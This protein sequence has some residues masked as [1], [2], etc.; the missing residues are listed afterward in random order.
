MK[1]SI[2]RIGV[3]KYIDLHLHVDNVEH[4]LGI[5]GGEECIE[6][7]SNLEEMCRELT[8]EMRVAFGEDRIPKEF[9]ERWIENG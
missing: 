9:I 1:L 3:N 4:D 6:F 7:L 8:E 5:H 2:R